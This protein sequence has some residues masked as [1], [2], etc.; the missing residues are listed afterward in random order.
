MG[1]FRKDQEPKRG[2][3]IELV[4]SRNMQ[5]RVAAPTGEGWQRME[6]GQH[7]DGMLAAIKC[8]HGAPPD[9]VALDAWVYAPPAGAPAEDLATLEARDWNAHFLA[10]MFASIDSLTVSTVDHATR[11]GFTDRALE[12]RVEGRLRTPEVTIRLVERHV[13]SGSKLLVVSAAASG[14]MHDR[15]GKIIDS[16][17][18]H[19]MLGGE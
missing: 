3:A 10:K 4:W 11:A 18:A 2:H 15:H 9:A 6:A 8:V 12:V 13:P 5:L 7:A 17:L 16:W 14:E 1:W 19:A